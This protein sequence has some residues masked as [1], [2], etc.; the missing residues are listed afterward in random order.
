MKAQS[1]STQTPA[2]E[3]TRGSVP[4]YDPAKRVLGKLCPRNHDYHG[5]G[6]SLRKKSRS[7]SCCAC[8]AEQKRERRQAT[9]QEVSA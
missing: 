5:T 1:T 8:D 9:R 6:Q 2:E 4:P 3:D 7:R